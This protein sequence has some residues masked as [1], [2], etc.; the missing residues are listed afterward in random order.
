[1]AEMAKQ[2]FEDPTE[3]FIEEDPMKYYV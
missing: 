2:G 1:M 3:K